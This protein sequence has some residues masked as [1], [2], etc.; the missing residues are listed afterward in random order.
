MTV[1]LIIIVLI[2]LNGVFAMSEMALASSRRF[3]LELSKKK[4]SKKAKTA[5][6]LTD[7]PTVFFSTTQIGMTV[8]GVFLG[9][10][11]NA[12]LQGSLA[13]Y[14]ARFSFF[15]PYAGTLASALMLIVITYFTIVL[16][17]LLPK[18]V[19]MTFPETIMTALAK[20]MKLLS[21]IASPFVWLLSKSNDLLL[22]M[23]GISDK[24]E[25][26]ASEEEIKSIIKDSAE[27]GEIQDIEQDIVE[28]V[29]E[30]GDRKA[31]TL[32][33]HRSEIKFIDIQDS[34]QTIVEKI[35]DEKHSAYPVC[36]E[37]NI[38]KVVGVITLKELFVGHCNAHFDIKNYIRTPLFIN[39]STYAYKIMELFRENKVHNGIVVD[40]YGSTIGII[41]MDDVIDALIGDISEENQDEYEIVQRDEHSWLVDGQYSIIEFLKQFPID[42]EP[43]DEYTTVA[44]MLIFQ[45]NTLPKVGSKFQFGNYELEVVD[46]DGQRIDKIMVTEKE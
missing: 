14:L 38:D 30:L 23:L 29:F 5:L 45:E 6:E 41:T 16:G 36:E 37:N 31:K 8:I 46:K 32:Y 2:L 28:R 1:F 7:R 11:T 26:A 39:E 21:Q 12:N 13:A 3:K 15:A 43:D 24:Q 18:R 4:G 19:G 33:T 35:N 40:E 20:P 22:K 34:W 27:E 25:G 17:E 44:G 10:Y 9:M 42:I